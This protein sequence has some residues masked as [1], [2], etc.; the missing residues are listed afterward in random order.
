MQY[1]KRSFAALVLFL[2]VTV[3]LAA[4]AQVNNVG[5]TWSNGNLVFH[6][7]SGTAVLT[8]AP[9]YVDAAALKIAGTAVSATGAELNQYAVTCHLAD[10]G[11]LGSAYV[12][13]PHAG[14]IVGVSVV[15]YAANAGT[16]TV[17]TA[18]I[19]GVSVTHPALEE[20]VTAAA[21]TAVTVVPT[22]ANAVTA[23]QAIEIA[24]DGGSS[25]AMPCSFTLTIAR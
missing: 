13:A 12:V 19:G 16:K 6:D 10:A 5:S 14:N 8:I 9:T 15:N 2:M 22:A 18:K 20:A 23:G 25:S 11:T 24:S 17:F 3:N 21:G 4:F 7:S 1:L